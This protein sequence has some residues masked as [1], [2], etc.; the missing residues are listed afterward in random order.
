MMMDRSQVFGVLE[1]PFLAAAVLLAFVVAIKLRGGAFG[2]GMQYL[3]WGFVVMAIGHVHMQIEHYAGI[4]LLGS[5]FGDAAGNVL[6]V[7]AL[8]TTWALS[9]YGFLQ[10]YWA[11]KNV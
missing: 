10:V 9:G 7:L 11:A 5:I 2:R 3:A 1:L 6:W 8:V 4:N